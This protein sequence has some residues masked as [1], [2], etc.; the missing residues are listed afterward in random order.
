VAFYSRYCL[1]SLWDSENR[2]PDR[3]RRGSTANFNRG[4]NICWR[5]FNTLNANISAN[6]QDIAILMERADSACLNWLYI[7]ALSFFAGPKVPNSINT[8]NSDFK[9]SITPLNEVR[10]RRG[11][12][13][14]NLRIEF[15][16]SQPWDQCSRSFVALYSSER[17]PLGWNLAKI[18]SPRYEVDFASKLQSRPQCMMTRFQHFKR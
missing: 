13:F 16:L 1:P 14:W 18:D 5:N 8:S 11:W 2:D 4:H 6:I 7:S 15:T 9:C 12:L 17:V 10:S 3:L